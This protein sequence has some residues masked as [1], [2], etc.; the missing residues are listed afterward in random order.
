MQPAQYSIG[1][2]VEG[3]ITGITKYGAFAIIKNEENETSGMVHISEISRGFVKDVNEHIKLNQI[4]KAV[5]IAINDD[6]KLAL[7]IKQMPGE[8]KDKEEIKIE[9]PDKNKVEKSEKIEKPGEFPE[10]PK[11]FFNSGKRSKNMVDFED[12][13]N[14]FKHDSDEKISD[15]KKSQNP[16]RTRRRSNQNL[17][18]NLNQNPNGIK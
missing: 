13:M 17:N 10:N 12:M 4:I 14:K 18:Q 1:S 3:R 11:D 16:K 2:I 5:V 7:S 9:K 6:G 15:L 8:Q